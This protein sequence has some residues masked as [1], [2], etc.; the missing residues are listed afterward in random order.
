[1]AERKKHGKQ[2]NNNEELTSKYLIA[3]RVVWAD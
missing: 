1:M 2:S 3:N